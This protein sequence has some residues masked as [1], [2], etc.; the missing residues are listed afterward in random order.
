[1]A[2]ADAVGNDGKVIGKPITPDHIWTIPSIN[3]DAPI[4][5]IAFLK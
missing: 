4:S 3:S 5:F 1:M 2:L